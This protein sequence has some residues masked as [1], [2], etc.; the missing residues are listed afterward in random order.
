MKATEERILKIKQM[1]EEFKN[2]NEL[3]KQAK[4]NYYRIINVPFN[5]GKGDVWEMADGF[6][7]VQITEGDANTAIAVR[8]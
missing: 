2:E 7:M 3:I 4:K 5:R 6:I 1:M 8:F